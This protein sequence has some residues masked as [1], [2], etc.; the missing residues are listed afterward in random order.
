MPSKASSLG[1]VKQITCV[2]NSFAKSTI[3]L[4]CS[5]LVGN[6]SLDRRHSIEVVCTQEALFQRGCQSDNKT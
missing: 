1:K 2:Y 6:A 3:F 5:W 4:Q